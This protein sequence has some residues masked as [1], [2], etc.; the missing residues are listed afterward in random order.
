VSNS[1][2]F[3]LGIVAALL[4]AFIFFAKSRLGGNPAPAPAPDVRVELNETQKRQIFEPGKDWVTAYRFRSHDTWQIAI[5]PSEA[6]GAT[7]IG[8]LYAKPAP[9]EV[10]VPLYLCDFGAPGK[11]NVVLDIQKD[12]SRHGK[13]LKPEPVGYGAEKIRTGYRLIFRC[14]SKEYGTYLSFK[15][16]CENPGDRIE[17]DLAAFRLVE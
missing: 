8:R 2:K 11:P 3:L 14:K 13:P 1:R 10:A 15:S 5:D 17:T 4:I 7:A 16:D 12:C 6:S 9:P